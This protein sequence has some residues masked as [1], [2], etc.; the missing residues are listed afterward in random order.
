MVKLL[1]DA[2]TRRWTYVLDS[3]IQLKSR[4]QCPRSQS[5]RQERRTASQNLNP[6]FSSSSGAL[7]VMKVSS[8]IPIA[9]SL[10]TWTSG[11]FALSTVRG[12]P[13]LKATVAS[14]KTL[15]RIPNPVLTSFWNGRPKEAQSFRNASP[16]SS[17]GRTA[18]NFGKVVSVLLGLAAHQHLHADSFNQESQCP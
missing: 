12:S 5:G 11:V 10:A 15:T 16:S 17:V 18:C 6:R 7:I 8:R 2:Q 4:R 3:D 13:S 14:M 9:L 1:C